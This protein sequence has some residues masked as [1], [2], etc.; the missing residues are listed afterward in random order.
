VWDANKIQSLFNAETAK[1]ILAVPILH[2]VH[3]DNLIREDDMYSV[4]TGYRLL[5]NAYI[6]LIFRL[7]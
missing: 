7:V 2:E 6:E 3:E 1:A 5:I 4:K